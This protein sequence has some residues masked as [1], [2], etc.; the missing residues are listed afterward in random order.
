MTPA[1]FPSGSLRLAV[2]ST[3]TTGGGGCVGDSVTLPGSS[4]LTTLMV[5]AM[6]SASLPSEAWKVTSY[7][8]PRS[9]S[10][11]PSKSGDARKRSSPASLMEK[12]P[13]SS[14]NS[15]H[16]ILLPS[17]SVAVYAPTEPEPFSE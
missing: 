5:T 12:S 4:T 9:A 10:V 1:T 14:P 17:G 2:S 3:P 16:L 7:S 8:L 11:G 15:D 13:A 6:E